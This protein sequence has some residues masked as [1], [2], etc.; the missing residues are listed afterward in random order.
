MIGI[1][2][3]VRAGYRSIEKDL[4]KGTADIWRFSWGFVPRDIRQSGHKRL[5][6]QDMGCDVLQSAVRFT[7]RNGASAVLKMTW[8]FDGRILGSLFTMRGRLS[9]GIRRHEDIVGK[10]DQQ[11]SKN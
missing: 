4:Q 11:P 10:Q 2:A 7:R 9:M 1:P 5:D 3:S 6:R 8:G